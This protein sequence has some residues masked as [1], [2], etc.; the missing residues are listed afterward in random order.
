LV[1][2]KNSMTTVPKWI[3]EAMLEFASPS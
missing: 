3:I 2:V 1:E